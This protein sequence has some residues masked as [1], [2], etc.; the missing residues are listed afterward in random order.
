VCIVRGSRERLAHRSTC[1]EVDRV[2]LVGAING[3]DSYVPE[4][5]DVNSHSR[6]IV[7]RVSRRGATR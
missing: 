7:E 3:H 6:I 1:G 2:G 4:V 5:L